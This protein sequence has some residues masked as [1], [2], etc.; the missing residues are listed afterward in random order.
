MVNKKQGNPC[1]R[2]F[3]LKSDNMSNCLV[4]AKLKLYYWIIS[5]GRALPEGRDERAQEIK[6]KK[7]NSAGGQLMH[8]GGG[9]RP[10][11][12]VWRQSESQRWVRQHRGKQ[13]QQTGSEDCEHI[14]GDLL[15]VSEWGNQEKHVWWKEIGS[16]LLFRLGKQI[17]LENLVIIKDLHGWGTG[18]SSQKDIPCW[19][20]AATEDLHGREC[21][22]KAPGKDW[23]GGSPRMLLTLDE[24]RQRLPLYDLPLCAIR[25]CWELAGEV[26]RS[27]AAKEIHPQH[28]IIITHKYSMCQKCA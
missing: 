11:S 10:K 19:L 17:I 24:Q 5:L 15:L 25:A 12:G 22:V 20:R 2:G 28:S 21:G 27:H 13:S 1:C 26:R 9:V 4:H 8:Q 18:S 16:S 23:A 14:L 3:P 7:G 6:P